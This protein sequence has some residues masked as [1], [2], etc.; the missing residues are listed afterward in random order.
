MSKED[1]A[2]SIVRRIDA[3]SAVTEP[4]S[5]RFG[6]LASAITGVA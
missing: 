2:E 1:G 5:L 4:C 3:I 6:Y